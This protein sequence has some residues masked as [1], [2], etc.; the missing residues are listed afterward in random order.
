VGF[1]YKGDI[2]ICVAVIFLLFDPFRWTKV[3]AAIAVVAIAMTLTRGLAIALVASIF[4]GIALNHNR[5]RALLLVGQC[6][7]LLTVLFVAEKVE[8]ETESSLLA[9]SQADGPGRSAGTSMDA[10]RSEK[11]VFAP[12]DQDPPVPGTMLRLGD[13]QRVGDFKFILERLDLS[14]ALFGRGLGAPIAGRDRIE[15]TYP[16]MLYKQ[17]LP[18]LLVWFLI[19]LY[20]FSLYRNVPPQ[21]KQFGLAFLLSSIFV[22]VV[23]AT[24]TFLTGSIGMAVVL[25]SL[26]SLLVLSR[27]KPT[28]TML[29]EEWYGFRGTV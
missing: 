6:V 7:L 15:S 23:T 18:A 5:T 12:S 3:L 21:T 1:F 8:T 2:Y 27:E 16:E 4:I 13:Y 28:A 26:A 22:Y 9:S 17:G 25:I 10:A 24:N 19:A 11:R 20:T 29:R 14:M